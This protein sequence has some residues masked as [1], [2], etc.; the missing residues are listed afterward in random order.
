VPDGVK[1]LLIFVVPALV[2]F[3]ITGGRAGPVTALLYVLGVAL[4]F[5]IIR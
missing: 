1:G 5:W 3:A 2:A 4:G